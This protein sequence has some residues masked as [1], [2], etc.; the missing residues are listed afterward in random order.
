MSEINDDELRKIPDADIWELFT[1]RREPAYLVVNDLPQLNTPISQ[2]EFEVIRDTVSNAPLHGSSDHLLYLMWFREYKFGME[3]LHGDNLVA[4]FT[5]AYA[6]TYEAH[7]SAG[8][9]WHFFNS[10]VASGYIEN[11]DV[12]LKSGWVKSYP[13]SIFGRKKAEKWFNDL[14]LKTELFD[15]APYLPEKSLREAIALT[16]VEIIGAN[17]ANDT[18]TSEPYN[19][20]RD[21]CILLL[22]QD[23]KS[24]EEVCKKINEEFPSENLEQNAAAEALKR[25]CKRNNI[26]YPRGKRGRKSQR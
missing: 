21:A 12:K 18:K 10:L 1:G 14:V 20:E 22:R 16:P 11:K 24:F 5:S 9:V 25:Y 2:G 26:K 15:D 17:T 8:T 23:G 3:P 4:F 19:A 13:V 7:V 6:L